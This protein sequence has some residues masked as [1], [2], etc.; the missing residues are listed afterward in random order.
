MLNRRTYMR[1]AAWVLLVAYLPLLAVSALHT[2]ERPDE[3]LCDQCAHHVEHPTHFGEAQVSLQDC[4][5]C[6]LATVHYLGVAALAAVPVLWV[7]AR[8]AV[9]RPCR[10]ALAA[11][12][13]ALLRAPPSGI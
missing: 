12:G 3:P 10:V 1:F 5:L 11:H 8:L 6:H 9:A 7:T 2:H 13:V 4:L